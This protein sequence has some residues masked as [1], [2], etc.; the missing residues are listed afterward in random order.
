METTHGYAYDNDSEQA[1]AHHRA[2]ADLLDRQTQ[3]RLDELIDLTG[4]RCLEVGA[5]GGS[6]AQWLADRVGPHGSVLATDLK[7]EHIPRSHLLTPLRHDITSG[8]PLGRFDLVHA[9]LLLGHL[10]AREAA[11]RHMADAVE[12][13]GV[14]MTEDFLPT[15][16]D[17]I[18]AWAPD[19]GTAELVDRYNRLQMGILERHGADRTWSRR[20]AAAYRDLGLAD[21]EVTAHGATWRGGGPGCRLL[22]AGL[23]QLRAPLEALGMTA[24]ELDQIAAALRDPRLVLNGYLVYLTSGQKPLD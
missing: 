13:G 4:R 19:P 5:G 7:P 9:R 23:G 1:E 18:V 11:L 21:I 15:P 16:D 12:P 20:A 2:L 3:W 24:A 6:V 8:E 10:P 17:E 14:L 22:L